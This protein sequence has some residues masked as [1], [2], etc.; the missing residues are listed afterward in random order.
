M[1]KERYKRNKKRVFEIYGIDPKDRR[2]SCHHIVFRSDR[3][4]IVSKDF[5]VN[6]PSNLYPLPKEIHRKLHE[7][8]G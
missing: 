8:V 6:Q 2:F 3:G 5:D 4:R 1:G 7:R